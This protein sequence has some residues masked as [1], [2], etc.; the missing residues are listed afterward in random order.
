[1]GHSRGWS[2]AAGS[3]RYPATRVGALTALH[4]KDYKHYKTICK[5]CNALSRQVWTVWRAREE[6]SEMKWLLRLY[7]RAWRE[8]YEEEMLALMEQHRSTCR[9]CSDLLRGAWDAQLDVALR[10]T[11]MNA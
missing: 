2:N 1:M 8:R 5:R 4:P 9:T 7:P 3:K 11:P 6:F 10:R